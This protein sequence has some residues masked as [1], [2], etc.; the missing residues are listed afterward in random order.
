VCVVL[1]FQSLCDF[2]NLE[3]MCDSFII[4]IKHESML[5]YVPLQN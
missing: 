3:S 4:K 1:L 2:V 5:L